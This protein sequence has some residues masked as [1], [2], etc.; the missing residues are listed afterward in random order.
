MKKSV[1]A[2]A[3]A[4]LISS[5][6][7]TRI[8]TGHTG[9][10]VDF[11]GNV[12]P[13]EKGVGWHQTLIGHIR[14]YV[15]NEM[16]I[17][18][19]DL[20]PQTKDRSTLSDLDM[21]FTYSI[22]PGAIA[23]LVVRYKGRDLETQFGTYPLG[24]Y[25]ANVVTTATTD[26]FSHYDALVANENREKIKDEIRAQVQKI[27]TEEKLDQQVHVHQVFIKNMAIDK[28]LQASALAVIA[29]QNDLKTK[30]FEV[31]TARKEAERLT[32]L[33]NNAASIDYMRAKATSD[34][35]EAVKAGKVNTIVI[36][37]DFKGIVNV[38]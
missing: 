11:N 2:L 30:D 33:A 12:E 17:E 32:L 9:V 29:S 36:P 16:T 1:I 18:L 4:A 15:A 13:T 20:R 14:E 25:V 10:R 19:N 31:Q 34:I 8:E 26:V 38:K 7:C 37:Y 27:L 21:V 28:S 6:G 5:V 24:A 3:V 23:D 22:N 35:A